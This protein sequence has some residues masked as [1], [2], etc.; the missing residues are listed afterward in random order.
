MFKLQLLLAQNCITCEQHIDPVP[1][2]MRPRDPL[3]GHLNLEAVIAMGFCPACLTIIDQYPI[4][5]K[6]IMSR[7]RRRHRL[8]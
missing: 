8:G 2:G 4:D 3:T 1:H 7:Y 6:K 5:W